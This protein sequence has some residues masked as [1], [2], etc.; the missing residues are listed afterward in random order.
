MIEAEG[1][2]VDFYGV[3]GTPVGYGQETKMQVLSD[4]CFS[5]V[6][7]T[8]REDNL[9]TEWLLDCYALGTIPIYWGCPNIDGFFDGVWDFDSPERLSEHLHYA[10]GFTYSITTGHT[11]SNFEKMQPYA[12]TEDWLYLNVLKEFE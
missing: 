11:S 8:Y 7:E 6:T 3:R 9:F 10:T 2:D 12:V 1:H 5:I 4:Y